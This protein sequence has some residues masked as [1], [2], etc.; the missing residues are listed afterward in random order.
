MMKSVSRSASNVADNF[1]AFTAVKIS[2]VLVNLMHI[3][4]VCYVIYL[5]INQL[6]DRESTE[7][8]PKK[9]EML[10]LNKTV[11]IISSIMAFLLCMTGIIGAILER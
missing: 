5:G 7:E 6:N 11:L 8:D 9:L 2:V 4:F 1:I 10:E 3:C